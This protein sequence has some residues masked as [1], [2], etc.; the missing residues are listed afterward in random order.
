[1]DMVFIGA[2]VGFFLVTWAF[3]AGCGKLGDGQ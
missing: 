2:I 1:M 3:A